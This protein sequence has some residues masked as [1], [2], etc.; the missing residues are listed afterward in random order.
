MKRLGGEGR[1]GP[2]RAASTP[3]IRARRPRRDRARA[4]QLAGLAVGPAVLQ[5]ALRRERRQPRRA[6]FRLQVHDGAAARTMTDERVRGGRRQSQRHARGLHDRLGRA[7][8]RRC[9]GRRLDRAAHARRRVD[10]VSRPARLYVATG[11]GP[12]RARPVARS[13]APPASGVPLR[14]GLDGRDP[15]CRSPVTARCGTRACDSSRTGPRRRTG[16]P[17][18]SCGNSCPPV[19]KFEHVHRFVSRQRGLQVEDRRRRAPPAHPRPNTERPRA[20]RADW[21]VPWPARVMSSGSNWIG[22]PRSSRIRR[23]AFDRSSNV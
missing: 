17:V 19:A 20:P 10:R 13:P 21:I 8:R 23:T 4:A 15:T 5:H 2:A 9:A 3:T 11:A 12:V 14:T 16:S 6:R 1:G 22:M 18:E 7:R